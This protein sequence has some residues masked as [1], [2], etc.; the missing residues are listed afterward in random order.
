MRAKRMKPHGSASAKKARSSADRV[1][2]AQPRMA[3]EA[4]PALR[5]L[6]AEALA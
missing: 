1:V 6:L 5:A 3:A 2:P 4:V